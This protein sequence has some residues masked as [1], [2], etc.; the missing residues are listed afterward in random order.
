MKRK[1]FFIVSLLNII[2]LI[3]MVSAGGECRDFNGVELCCDETGHIFC[4]P[5]SYE[6]CG[7]PGYCQNLNNPELS[8]IPGEDWCCYDAGWVVDYGNHKCCSPDYP[9][10]YAPTDT[11]WN[12]RTLSSDNYYTNLAQCNYIWYPDEMYS[13]WDKECFGIEYRECKQNQISQWIDGWDSQILLGK[14]GVT[15][16]TDNN[17]PADEVSDKFCSANNIMETRIDHYCSSNYQCLFLTQDIILETCPFKC[18][19]IEG[20]G[21]I[22]IDKICETG[23]LM[24]SDEENALICQNNQWELKEECKYGCED[25]WCKSFYT[26]KT[27][28]GI[29]AGAISLIILLIILI[30]VF[31]S[32]KKRRK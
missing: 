18:E 23:E 1:I 24:C 3:G 4:D 17:C 11:C 28:Y 30:V 22:C 20:E 6:V 15:C 12:A 13:I 2:L 9:F 5:N 10:Y 7:D 32:K 25:G 14:C 16:L 21:V 27:F 26:T 19:E 29:I 31:N 8:C